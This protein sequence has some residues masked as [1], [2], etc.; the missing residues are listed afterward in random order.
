MFEKGHE[1]SSP[2][3]SCEILLMAFEVKGVFYSGMNRVNE[4]WITL[5]VTGFSKRNLVKEK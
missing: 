3:A 2:V 1:K 4:P 5:N